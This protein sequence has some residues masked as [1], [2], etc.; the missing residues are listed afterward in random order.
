MCILRKTLQENTQP[1]KILQHRMQHQRRKRKPQKKRLPILPQTQ[2]KNKPN[3]KRHT[4][5]RTK[6]QPRPKQRSWNNTK[7][8]RTNRTTRINFLNR[9]TLIWKY[10]KMSHTNYT[11][12]RTACPY[13]KKTP[14]IRDN[15]RQETYCPKCGLVIQDTTIPSI[16]FE[17]KQDTKNETHMRGIW[18]K[19]KFNKEQVSIIK[20]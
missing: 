17:I 15:I 8:N 3:T 20:H 16:T 6:T 7:R 1:T 19:V 14:C 5:N 12:I 2:N 13:C 9:R 11:T 10:G 4:V 18:R